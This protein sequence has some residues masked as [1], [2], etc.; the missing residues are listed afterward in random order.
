MGVTALQKNLGTTRKEAQEFY[1][2]YFKRLPK[3]AEYLDETILQAKKLG[4]TQTLFGRRRHFPALRS[5]LPYIK[6]MAE[7]A[8]S[9]A[10][11]QGMPADMIKL[12]MIQITEKLRDA[13]LADKV[14][15][16]MQIHDELVFEVADE[17]LLQAEKIIKE[18]MENVLETVPFDIQN[19]VP[20]EVS[21]SSGKNWGET[22]E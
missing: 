12:A 8:A 5:P 14:H 22:K 13:G 19:K 15:M 21:V 16:T 10:P 11:I 6:A 3:L 4:Y 7:R 20:I 9:N 17:V 2:E 18:T 1:D